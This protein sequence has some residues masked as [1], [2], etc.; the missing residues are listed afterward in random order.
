MASSRAFSSAASS[1]SK[2]QRQ[3]GV[4]ATR[5]PLMGQRES[6]APLVLRFAHALRDRECP[7]GRW[8]DVPGQMGQASPAALSQ[9]VMMTSIRGAFLGEFVP[10]LGA[11]EGRYRSP[12]IPETGCRPDWE[13][14]AAASRPRR[15]GSGPAASRSGSLRPGSIWRNWPCTGKAR[16][17]GWTWSSFLRGKAS[18]GFDDGLAEFR[19]AV[20][21][22]SI[23]KASRSRKPVMSA[24]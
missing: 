19:R 17:A 12:A 15:R 23:R 11:R 3:E 20:Q 6:G 21:Q 16:Y 24:T 2:R 18:D 4:D 8:P 9:T 10:A 5:K 22:S 7:N 14:R 13:C 1:A